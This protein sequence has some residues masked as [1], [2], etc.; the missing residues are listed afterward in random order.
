VTLPAAPERDEK[1][2]PPRPSP[3]ALKARL[4][5]SVPTNG[6]GALSALGASRLA[7]TLWFCDT[8]LEP[9]VYASGKFR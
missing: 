3:A 6:T 4:P 5:S 9:D 2:D 1:R 8:T 7:A